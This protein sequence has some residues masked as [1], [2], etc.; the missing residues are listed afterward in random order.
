MN[1][2]NVEEPQGT[3]TPTQMEIMEVVWKCGNDGVIA[4]EIWQH[5]TQRRSVVRTTVLNQVDRLE[6]RGWVRR[7][8]CDGGAKF[9]AVLGREATENRLAQE[10]LHD[11]FNGSVSTLVSR[12]FGN[13]SISKE[14]ANQMQEMIDN[15]P[16]TLDSETGPNESEKGLTE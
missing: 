8:Q 10:F 2:R 3:L 5:I 15:L 6:K 16:K 4:S 14:D 13:A 7:E 1:R 11:F 9:F 12:L